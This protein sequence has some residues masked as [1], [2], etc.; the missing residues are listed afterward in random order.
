M[1]NK[2]KCDREMEEKE[3]KKKMRRMDGWME[4]KMEERIE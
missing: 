1:F 3:G 4:G 2:K